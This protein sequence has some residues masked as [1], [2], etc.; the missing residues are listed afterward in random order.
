MFDSIIL[1]AIYASYLING[2]SSGL[3]P[4]EIMEC[5][6]LL[7]KYEFFDCSEEIFSSKYNG[8]L[9]GCL[10]FTIRGR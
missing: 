2:D 6:I 9:T 8:L 10:E 5:N 1:P 4:E 7:T 3:D